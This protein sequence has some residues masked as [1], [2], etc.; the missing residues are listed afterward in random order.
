M[1]VATIRSRRWA[2]APTT[3]HPR[4]ITRCRRGADKER[5]LLV[6]RFLPAS[7][8]SAVGGWSPAETVAYIARDRD[9]PTSGC[10]G[11][12][13]R[14]APARR[15]D[16]EPASIAALTVYKDFRLRPVSSTRISASRLIDRL[17]GACAVAASAQ[18]LT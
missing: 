17:R 8:A 11:L 9:P 10:Q 1:T 15:T 4:P 7:L 3:A 12:L 18:A 2:C 5:P 16:L 14:R 13:L 6:A